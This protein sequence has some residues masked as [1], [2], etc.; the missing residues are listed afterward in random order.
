MN[1]EN[2]LYKAQTSSFYSNLLN[3][4]LWRMIPFNKPHRFK[5]SVL[6]D[7][8]LKVTIPYSRR[9]MNHLKGIHACALAT[10]SEYV[11]GLSLARHL[12]PKKY[13]YILQRLEM[14]Y[15]Y[16]AKKAVSGSFGISAE[17]VERIKAELE[18]AEKT[19]QVFRVEL[20]DAE[21][22][23][24]CTAVT[25]WQLKDWSRVKTRV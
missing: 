18:N 16:Q 19:V 5:I 17:E 9:N 24:I 15:T 14:D 4:V 10:A 22:N 6:D 11:C 8:Q 2:I 7:R 23:L 12:D 1:L 25:H 21:K 20:F 3:R 13:R